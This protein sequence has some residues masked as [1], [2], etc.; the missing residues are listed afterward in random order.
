[1]YQQEMILRQLCWLKYAPSPNVLV[2]RIFQYTSYGPVFLEL[3][4][5]GNFLLRE[6]TFWDPIVFAAVEIHN[7]FLLCLRYLLLYAGI[8]SWDQCR[9]GGE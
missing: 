8:G 6:V 7:L 5:W 3:C 9:F 4:G 1:M 2:D